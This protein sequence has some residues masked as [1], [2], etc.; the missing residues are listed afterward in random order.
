MHTLWFCCGCNFGPHNAAI[1]DT[2]INCGKHA[3]S[4]CTHEQVPGLSDG[5]EVSQSPQRPLKGVQKRVIRSS[6]TPSAQPD[7]SIKYSHK[8]P[9]KPLQGAQKPAT[10]SSSKPSARRDSSIKSYLQMLARGQPR[11]LV[12]GLSQDSSH[13]KEHLPVDGPY[14]RTLGLLIQLVKEN[15]NKT[16][17]TQ[18]RDELERL[19]L[20]GES[21]SLSNPDKKLLATL[22]NSPELHEN[23]LFTLHKLESVIEGGLSQDT[24]AVLSEE[25]EIIDIVDD[26]SVYIDCLMDLSPAIESHILDNAV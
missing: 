17:K 22:K 15:T 16:H 23:I 19:F 11:A 12:R 7:D 5:L 25:E 13:K 21:F 8:S 26:I 2:C 20:W 3:C 14:K 24:T 4:L 6:P 9:Q 18:L 10:Q 1:Y